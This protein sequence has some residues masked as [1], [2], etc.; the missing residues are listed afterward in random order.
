MVARERGLYEFLLYDVESGQVSKWLDLPG[1]YSHEYFPRLDPSGRVLVFAASS[2]GHELDIEDYEIFLWQVG[3]PA[4]EAQ[5]LTFSS[6]ND[7]WP[8]IWLAPR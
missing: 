7:S 4:A 2:G 6:A 5:R 3:R 1:E 8:D